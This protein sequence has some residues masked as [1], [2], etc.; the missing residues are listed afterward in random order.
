MGLF[1]L[2]RPAKRHD[3]LELLTTVY[4]NEQLAVLRSILD[5]G[6]IPYMTKERGSGS[7][8]KII[9]GFSMYGTDIFVKREQLDEARALL[10][11]TAASDNDEQDQT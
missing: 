3:D 4:D 11:A 9:M 10:E 8:V 1:G 7:S 6:G 5:D 2:D